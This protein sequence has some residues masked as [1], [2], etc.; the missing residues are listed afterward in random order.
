MISIIIPVYNEEDELVKNK[1]FYESLHGKA[2]LLFADGE[3]TDKSTEIAKRFGRV[4]YSKRGRGIQMNSAAKDA[5]GDILLFLHADTRI[6]VGSLQLIENAV[7][8]ENFVGG[9]LTQE[10]DKK[11]IIYRLIE[12]EGNL[13]ARISKIFYGDQGIFVKKDVFFKINGFP[14]TPIMEDVLFT[15]KIRNL[16]KTAIFP[17]KIFVS[18]RRWEKKGILKTAFI[19]SSINILFHMGVSLERIKLRYKDLR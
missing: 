10:I 11:G 4:I 17:D 9:C 8:N 3:S 19:Y 6:L 7:H 14:E 15:K 16:G 18:P 13:R 1:S 2:E 12:S 5:S